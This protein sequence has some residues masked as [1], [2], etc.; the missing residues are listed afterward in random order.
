MFEGTDLSMAYGPYDPEPPAA[1]PAHAQQVHP[2]QASH[3]QAPDVQYAPPPAMYNTQPGPVDQAAAAGGFYPES[4]WDRMARKKGDLV[5]V[6]MIALMILLALS[7]D[8]TA[9]HYLSTYVDSS[10]L[11]DMQE[12]IVRLSY[13]VAVILIVWVIKAW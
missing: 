11:T 6:I 4:F 10:I 5:K 7:L 8:C 2:A 12:F 1:M 13:P 9:R 3:A